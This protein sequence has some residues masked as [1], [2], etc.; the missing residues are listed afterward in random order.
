DVGV[1]RHRVGE[2]APGHPGLRYPR[3][4]DPRAWLPRDRDRPA[5]DAARP[6]RTDLAPAPLS[7]LLWPRQDLAEPAA[8]C[9]ARDTG[10]PTAAAA[11][12]GGVTH[13]PRPSRRRRAKILVRPHDRSP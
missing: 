11:R 8:L 4:D 6:D 3:C 5:P 13:T 7:A 2:A 1:S 12:E 10:V 9:R